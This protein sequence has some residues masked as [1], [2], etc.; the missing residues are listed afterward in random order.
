MIETAG[1]TAARAPLTKERV[2]QA[3]V[4]IADR[5]GV[6]ALSMRALATELGAGAMSLYHYVANKDDL[7]DGMVD[8]VFDE[9]TLP[10]ADSDW[11]VAVRQRMLA[12]RDA[13]A[14]HPWAIVLMES[15]TQPGLAN[16]QHREAVLAV[17]RRAGFSVVAAT[18]ANWLLDSYLYGFALQVAT[19]P[20]DTQEEL[21]AMTEQ[22]FLPQIPADRYPHLNEAAAELVASGYDPDTEFEVGLDLIL[23]A[24]EGLRSATYR[25]VR[26]T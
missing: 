17:L 18:H 21:A 6:D 23:D 12:T 4:A 22:V 25:A 15:R 1:R 16:L 14:R 8:L 9:I 10:S 5:R 13:L 20:F 24:L 7:L 2:L 3:A 19:L 26:R 11:R